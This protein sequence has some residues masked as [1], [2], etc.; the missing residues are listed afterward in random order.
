MLWRANGTDLT[1][2]QLLQATNKL[3][4]LPDQLSG[5]AS[6]YDVDGDGVID[7]AEARL[8]TLAN[9]LYSRINSQ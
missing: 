5:F 6:I 1:V 3:T 9:D 7:A 2:M 4:D 8:R